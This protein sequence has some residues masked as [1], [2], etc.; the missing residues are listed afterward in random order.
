MY[1]PR[2]DSDGPA[3]VDIT[4]RNPLAQ[5]RPVNPTNMETWH[6]RQ[7]NEKTVKYR[8]ACQRLGWKFIPFVVD[9]YGGLGNQAAY[10][11]QSIVKNAAGQVE[12]WQ[13][14]GMEATTWQQIS[15]S[16]MKDVGKQLV[17]SV[18]SAMG[19]ST[20]NSGALHEPYDA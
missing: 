6:E 5:S 8:V 11:V 18:Y 10:V 3:A 1:F 2:F 13:R 14:R 4:I 12:G 19:P 7:E 20:H 15:I 9:T 16:L 17:W